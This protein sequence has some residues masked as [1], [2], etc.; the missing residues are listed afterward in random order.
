MIVIFSGVGIILLKFLILLCGSLNLL[1][2]PPELFHGVIH[3]F[4]IDIPLWKW[5]FW[6]IRQAM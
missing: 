3:E 5:Y 6:W 1:E 2:S 4:L